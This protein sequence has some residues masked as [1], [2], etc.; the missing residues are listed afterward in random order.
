MATTAEK[1]RQLIVWS[2]ADREVAL[3]T[4]FLYTMN[5][6]KRGWMD[7]VTLLIW[8]PS[9]KL[10]VEDPELQKGLE[11]L[12]EVGVA[13]Y[14]CKACSDGLGVSDELT[15]L[16]VNVQYTGTLLADAQKN[17][18]YVLTF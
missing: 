16:G 4:V 14:A 11:T 15:K 12:K 5:A 8:G 13:L 17:G 18:W 3:K 10:L 6:K 7:E 2:S 9:G 1:H